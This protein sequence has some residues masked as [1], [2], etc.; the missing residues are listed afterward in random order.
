L[1]G[2]TKESGDLTKEPWWKIASK[3]FLH[4][5]LFSI[6]FLVLAF[7]WAVLLVVLVLVGSLIGLIIGF[8]VLFFIIGGVNSVLTNHIWSIPTE[9]DWKSLFVHG[10]IL[11]ISL[12]IVH[13][14][15]ILVNF[16]MPGWAT[17]VVLFI[18]Y[19]FIDGLVGKNVAGWRLEEVKEYAPGETP[20]SFLKKCIN[21]GQE[22][23]IAELE[24]S[25]CG[26]KQPE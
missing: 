25:Y 2:E 13:V 16:L 23:P 5:I 10:F 21:C 6:I 15:S 12:F 3:Y 9:K 19:A 17:M 26:T 1:G 11:S 8:A 24:C 4:G 22:I 14:P 18:V 20:K 7:L